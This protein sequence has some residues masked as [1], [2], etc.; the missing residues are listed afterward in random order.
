VPHISHISVLHRYLVE[1]YA[2]VKHATL[3]NADYAILHHWFIHCNRF[4]KPLNELHELVFAEF[5]SAFARLAKLTLE[6][7]MPLKAK[8]DLVADAIIELGLSDVGLKNTG[9]STSR[10]K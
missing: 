1:H 2:Y 4:P 8:I 7:T 9:S 3:L 6:D 10:R 5:V